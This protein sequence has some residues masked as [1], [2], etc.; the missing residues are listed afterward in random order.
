MP[1]DQ[2]SNFGRLWPLFAAT[3]V[4]AGFSAGCLRRTARNAD[5]SAVTA[6]ASS[7]P[8]APGRG[9]KLDTETNIPPASERTSPVAR[10]GQLSVKGAQLVD[11][12]G[13]PVVLRGQALGWDNWWPRYY[14]AQVYTGSGKI[15]ASTSCAPPWASSPM[16]PT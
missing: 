12:E 2:S 4:A 6:A 8:A 15:G 14:N 13:K 11:A 10:H 5:A 1:L 3:V 16:E 7:Q 9:S